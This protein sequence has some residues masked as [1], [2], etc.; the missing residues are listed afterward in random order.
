[1]RGRV[2]ELESYRAIAKR[3]EMLERSHFKHLQYNRR[4]SIEIAGIPE[5]VSDKELENKSLLILNIIGVDK[6]EPWQVHACHRLKNKKNTIIRFVSRKIADS[7]LYK[8]GNLK[9]ID[10]TLIGLPADTQL[11]INENLCPP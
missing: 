9:K 7:A 3:V 6:V 4:E 2:E 8:R 5:S 11:Y 1:M 10:K